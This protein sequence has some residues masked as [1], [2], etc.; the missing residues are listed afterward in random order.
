[1]T[2]QELEER[3][4]DFAVLVIKLSAKLP[5]NRVGLI[6][7]NQIAK[8]G[9]SAAL[10]YGE[11]RG[12]QSRKDFI[13]KS[14]IVLKELRETYVCLKIIQKSDLIKRENG[15]PDVLSECN[16]LVSIF[17]KS[18]RTSKGL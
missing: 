1:M 2:N 13:H 4:T 9:T 12:A 17:V 7:C 6:L 10:N 8:S 18:V 16:E 11:V 15:L 3:L 14:Q 5:R